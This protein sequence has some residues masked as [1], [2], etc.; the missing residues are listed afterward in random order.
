M[1]T[2]CEEPMGIAVYWGKKHEADT[3]ALK[4]P[5]VRREPQAVVNI[6]HAGFR[7]VQVRFF[8]LHLLRK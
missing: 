1:Q 3:V 5:Q 2:Q 7:N 8:C 6:V 4:R